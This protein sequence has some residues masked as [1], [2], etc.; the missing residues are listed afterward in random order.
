M[1]RKSKFSESEI[2]A[3]IAEIEGGATQLSVARKLGV[4]HQ[5]LL[6][7]RRVYGGMTVPEAQDKKRLEEE[8]ARLKR[9]VATYAIELAAMKE[10]LGKKW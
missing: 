9:A 7:W 1:A 5:T 8:N 6:R 3:A 4:S 2:L 10:A